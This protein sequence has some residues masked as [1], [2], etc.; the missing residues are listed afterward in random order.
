MVF[1]EPYL[2]PDTVLSN[3]TLGNKNIGLEKVRGI[4]KTVQIDDYIMSLP[5]K[6]N[7]IIGDRGIKLYI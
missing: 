7:S 1:Q 4:C 3:L 6:Y 5:N 2:L